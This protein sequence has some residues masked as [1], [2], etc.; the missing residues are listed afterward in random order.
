[1]LSVSWRLE[2][3]APTSRL[4]MPAKSHEPASPGATREAEKDGD[5]RPAGS[6]ASLSPSS[7]RS[8]RHTYSGRFNE[9]RSS[10]NVPQLGAGTQPKCM[11]DIT[12]ACLPLISGRPDSPHSP[13]PPP[14]PPNMPQFASRAN[15]FCTQP[16]EESLRG[17]LSPPLQPPSPADAR[18]SGSRRRK[19]ACRHLGAARAPFHLLGVANVQSARRLPLLQRARFAARRPGARSRLQAARRLL[20]PRPAGDS[21]V[22]FFPW[23]HFGVCSALQLLWRDFR[24]GRRGT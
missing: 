21:L 12:N 4:E 9:E 1:M 13:L 6:G 3:P 20:P 11:H 14:A 24:T 7:L 8:H 17:R 19:L 23:L 10:C 15:R 5:R 2:D 18:K 16:Y 22:S